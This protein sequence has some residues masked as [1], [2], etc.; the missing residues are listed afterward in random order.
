MT[1]TKTNESGCNINLMFPKDKNGLQVKIG[2]KIRGFGSIKFQDGFL[3][4]R[5][6][7][8]TA[9]IQNDRL[10]FGHLSCE[11]FTEFEIV[12]SR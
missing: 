11:S 10:Y 3:I 8:V 5:T 2:D 4:D 7:I 1:E 9:N 6:P 12:N